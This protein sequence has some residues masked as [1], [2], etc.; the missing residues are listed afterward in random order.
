MGRWGGVWGSGRGGW[1]AALSIVP[2]FLPYLAH[3][4]LSRGG[5]SSDS[6]L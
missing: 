3:P 1:P 2:N 5:V 4:V 6:D